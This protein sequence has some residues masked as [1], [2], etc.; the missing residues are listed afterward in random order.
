MRCT[1]WAW[2][3]SR[4]RRFRPMRVTSLNRSSS[5][6]QRLIGCSRSSSSVRRVSRS[7]TFSDLRFRARK[8]TRSRVERS[9]QCTSS[10]T[11]ISGRSADSLHTRVKQPLE[12]P[13]LT[14]AAEPC[15]VGLAGSERRSVEEL[16]RQ[17]VDER[18][19]PLLSQLGG[20]LRR[21]AAQQTSQRRG[22]R[23]E[24]HRLALH[25]EAVAQQLVAVRTCGGARQPRR[26]CLSRAHPR[27]PR[28]GDCPRRRQAGVRAGGPA[29]PHARRALPCD[30]RP[31]RP[32]AKMSSAVVR[33]RAATHST[34]GLTKRG[35]KH[36]ERRI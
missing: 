13:G 19:R 25:R 7:T 30:R 12:E 6:S 34:A 35:N 32:S 26:T 27:P 3:A 18:P 2:V 31:Q 21:K 28:P 4:V 14:R 22:D 11:Q 15:L 17:E 8:P 1:S 33:L 29:R 5:T 16:E 9:D 24:G 23:G 20:C 10:I 36:L